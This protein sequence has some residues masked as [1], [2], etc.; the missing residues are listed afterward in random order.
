MGFDGGQYGEVVNAP[1]GAMAGAAFSNDGR[2]YVL[3]TADST[4]SIQI[5]TMNVDGTGTTQLT[6]FTSASAIHPVWSPDGSKIAFASNASGNFQIWSMNPDGTG[7]TNLTNDGSLGGNDYP[8]WSPDST[9]IAFQ[10]LR[11]SATTNVWDM[12]ADGTSQTNLTGLTSFTFS[13]NPSYSPDGT[14]ITF[15]T[16]RDGNN[17]IYNDLFGRVADAPD[18][19]L[20]QRRQPRLVARRRHDCLQQHAQRRLVQNLGHEDRR[21]APD[22]ASQAGLQLLLQSALVA[23]H[24][25]RDDAQLPRLAQSL[26]R[27]VRRG[28]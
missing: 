18:E 5:F 26:G 14:Q 4:G 22:A 6:S 17:E 23:R 12:N 27:R 10:R 2:K 24:F 13:G 21:H 1:T 25:G 8:A 3:A 15:Q 19:Q 9:K 11:N 20:G 7:Q 16:D 28:D